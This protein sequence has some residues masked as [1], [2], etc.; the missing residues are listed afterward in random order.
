MPLNQTKSKL[1][2]MMSFWSF[3][4]SLLLTPSRTRCLRWLCWTSSAWQCPR[5]S[6][7]RCRQGSAAW[8]LLGAWQG[9]CACC[10][11]QGDHLRQWRPATASVTAESWCWWWWMRA[12]AASWCCCWWAGGT[13]WWAGGCSRLASPAGGSSCSC[14]SAGEG[15]W[16]CSSGCLRHNRKG[17]VLLSVF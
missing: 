6:L 9:C 8:V 3:F 12:V 11:C 15:S 4:P 10:G 7:G 5:W 1:D 13:L 16:S 17:I 14:R 2:Y